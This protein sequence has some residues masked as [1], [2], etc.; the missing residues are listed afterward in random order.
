MRM[1]MEMWILEKIASSL[2]TPPQSTKNS[3]TSRRKQHSCAP[4]G[5]PGVETSIIYWLTIPHNRLG[6][7]IFY[8]SRSSAS[9][10]RGAHF[11]YR[12]EFIWLGDTSLILTS[13]SRIATRSTLA[14]VKAFRRAA[15]EDVVPATVVQHQKT[16]A[17][18]HLC[19]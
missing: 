1:R 16:Q 6:A 8:R 19:S 17:L 3:Q 15:D 9:S 18:R 5:S 4:L 13:S 14:A 2:S 10:L 7:Y 11:D 12:R